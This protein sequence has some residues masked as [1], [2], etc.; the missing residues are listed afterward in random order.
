MVV[1]VRANSLKEIWKQISVKKMYHK[2]Q[3][4]KQILSKLVDINKIVSKELKRRN[5]LLRVQA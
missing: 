4:K 3:F 1:W 2:V 5:L